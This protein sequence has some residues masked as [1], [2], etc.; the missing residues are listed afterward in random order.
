MSEQQEASEE[1]VFYERGDV[2]RRAGVSSG[3]VLRD[4]MLGRIRPVAHTVR[5]VRLFDAAT[6]DAYLARRRGA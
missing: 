5:G 4:I 3:T 6:V 2:A 1:S